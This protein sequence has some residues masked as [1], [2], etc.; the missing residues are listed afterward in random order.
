VKAE[1]SFM[2]VIAANRWDPRPKALV[3]RWGKHNAGVVTAEDLSRA[4]WRQ[5]SNGT[6][7]NTA[8]VGG[9][10]VAQEEVTGVLT[11][12][13]CVFAEELAHI[14]PEDR[15]YVAAEMTAFL[16]FWLS[17]LQYQCP[18]LNRPTSSC[19]SGP[20]WRREKWIHAAAQAGIPMQTLH[21]HTALPTSMEKGAT[22]CSATVTVVGK[23]T[24]G[25]VESDLQRQARC[26]ADLAGV[27]LLTIRFSGPERGASFMSADSLPDF[28]HD[29][30]AD[31][32]LEYLRGRPAGCA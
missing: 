1:I 5:H 16:L 17:R 23:C 6:K 14:A 20:S 27:D 11:L 22:H 18:V 12:L 8:V 2:I 26:L 25:E 21:R 13:P 24:F 19:L 3:S 15:S 4:G 32:V 30:L 10:L 28:S 29:G 7:R 9:K 31:A